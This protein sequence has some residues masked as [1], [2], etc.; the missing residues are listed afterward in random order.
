MQDTNYQLFSESVSEEVLLNA[1]Y[2]EQ[3]NHVLEKLNLLDVEER[4]PMSLSG[5]QKQRVAIASAMLSGKELIIFDEPTSGLDYVNMQRFGE[6]LNMLKETEAI[7]AIITH[8]V[9]LSSEWC[10]EI[11]NFNNF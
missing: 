4:H 9:E 6:L 3:K 10:D 8:D 7:I 11:I 1:K 5:G 2:P